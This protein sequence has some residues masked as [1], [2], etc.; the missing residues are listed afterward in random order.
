MKEIFLLID[1]GKILDK[2]FT[3]SI[4]NAE[5]IFKRDRDWIFSDTAYCISEADYLA[6][7]ELNS[8]ESQT[9]EG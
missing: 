6:E 3:N 9:Y 5:L 1:N 7:T 4:E 2:V 8:L